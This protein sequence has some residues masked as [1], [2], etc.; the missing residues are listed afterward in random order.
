ME[1]ASAC[2]VCQQ[3]THYSD[4]CPELVKDL[5]EGFY[6]P[7]GGMPQGGGD[8]DESLDC[9]GRLPLSSV[10]IKYNTGSYRYIQRTENTILANRDN[11]SI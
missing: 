9:S 10:F 3:K 4:S 7:A 6:K 1:K 11:G 2:C 5:G 8:D